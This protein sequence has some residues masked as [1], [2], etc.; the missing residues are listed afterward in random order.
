M[1]KQ[2]VSNEKIL[3]DEKNLSGRTLESYSEQFKLKV[4]KEMISGKFPSKE[5]ARRHYETRSNSAILEWMRLYSGADGITK[6]GR[7]LKN[8][9]I[10]NEEIAKQS[11][12]IKELEAALHK[13]KLKVELSNAF[14]DIAKEKYGIDL[15]KKSGAKQ[16]NELKQNAQK[17]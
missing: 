11:M 1:K 5:A 16:F 10:M 7:L 15:R 8:R 17:K 6:S 14:I 2:S 4:V 9:D 3:P 13:E 12:R